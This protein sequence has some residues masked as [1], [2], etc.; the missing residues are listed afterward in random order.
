MPGFKTVSTDTSGMPYAQNDGV[1]VHYDR[2]GP[3]EAPT[4]A[5]LEGLGYG[6][7]MWQWQ[8]DA[9]AD[10][11]ETVVI[12][13]RG[14]GRSDAPD[15]TYTIDAMAADLEAVLMDIGAEDVH[16]VGASMGGMIVQQY[17]VAYDRHASTVLLCTSHGGEEAVP[18]PAETV[19]RIFDVPEGLGDREAIRYKMAPALSDGF[20]EDNPELIADIVDWRLQ[21]D[22]SD[23]ARE[24]QG[25]AVEAFDLSDRVAEISV[26]TLVMHG[27]AD[28]VLPVQN[29]RLLHEKL[30]NSRLDLFEDGPHLFFI[31]DAE[32]VNRR[33]MEFIDA[34]T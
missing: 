18:T 14:T 21:Q 34:R 5:F 6:K 15:G 2:R 24:A 8:R 11:Y 33:L 3:P 27:T 23:R 12:D 16:L 4:V 17:A 30:P 26:P 7:W 20:I 25:E 19:D 22:A 31:E 9:L 13:N 10:T 29:G 28:K 32:T 1:A